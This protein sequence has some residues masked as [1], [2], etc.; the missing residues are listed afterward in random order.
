MIENKKYTKIAK[1]ILHQCE[2][3]ELNNTISIIID[4]FTK[5]NV[6]LDAGKEKDKIQKNIARCAAIVKIDTRTIILANIMLYY[7]LEARLTMGKKLYII[8]DSSDIIQYE[9][10][11]KNKKMPAYKILPNACLYE[12]DEYNYLSLFTLERPKNVCEKYHNH[13]EYYASFS[14]IWFERIQKFNGKINHATQKILFDT[15]EDQENFYEEFGLEPDEQKRETQ[16]KN[17][18]DIKNVRTWASFYEEHKKNGLYN[19]TVC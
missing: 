1:Y 16:D 19:P 3:C 7:S 17:M 14:P 6:I 15:D 5:R 10:I 9:T 12:I 4:V 11:C 2:T 8:I 13:W 18:K